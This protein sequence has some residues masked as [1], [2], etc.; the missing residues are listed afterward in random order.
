MNYKPSYRYIPPIKWHWQTPFYDFLCALTGLGKRFRE[1]VL[2]SISLRDGYTVADIGCGT[3]VFLEI[4]KRRY[5]AVQFVGLDPDEKALDIAKRQLARAGLAVELTQAY[6]ESLPLASD[7]IDVC[8]STLAFHHMPD[9]IKRKAAQE[10]YRALKP[11]GV[12]VIA[13][14]GES[15]SFFLRKLL[16][17][18]KI[19]YLEGNLKGFIPRY[20]QE[21][22]FK[23]P[24]VVGAHFPGI[25]ILKAQK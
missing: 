10:I 17:F 22:G 6:A 15:K 12:V 4:A 19:E 21:A 24:E 25:R 18:E 2:Q 7:S 11:G 5:P 23:A 16:F 3:G 13:D 1:K 20:L 8:F 14:F 9:E